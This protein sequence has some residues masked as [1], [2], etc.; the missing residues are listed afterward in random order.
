M[1]KIVLIGMV[2]IFLA[3]PLKNLKPEYGTY[4]SLAACLMIAA[5]GLVKLEDI[6]AD[7]DKIRSYLS[8]QSSYLPIL[9][10]MIG[11]TYIS[12]LGSALCKDAGYQA[13]ASQIEL[14]GKLTILVMGMPIL[15]SLLEVIDGIL[16]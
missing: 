5:L 8:I 1:V 15:L 3:I 12:Q 2:A 16:P 6:L 11:I 13:V 10:K 4:V 14:A 7:I 9:L